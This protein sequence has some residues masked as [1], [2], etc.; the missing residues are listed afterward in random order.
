MKIF[1]D[2]IAFNLQKAGGISVYWSELVKRFACSG[3]DMTFIEQDGEIS[4]IF[5][6]QIDISS[7][8]IVY[9]KAM[10]TRISR[11]LSLRLNINSPSVFHSSYFR[12]CKN[13]KA[14]NIVTV[15]DCTYELFSSGLKQKVHLW[16]KKQ[17]LNSADSI[18]CVSENTKSDLLKFYTHLPPH[19]V[20]VIYNGAGDDFFPL[21]RNLHFTGFYENIRDKKY[22]LYVGGRNSYK[23]FNI[24]IEAVSLLNDFSLVAVGGGELTDNENI[25]LSSIRDRF[26]HVKSP[27]SKDLNLLYNFAFCLLYPSSYEGFGIPIAEAMKAGCPVVTSSVSSIPEVAGDAGLMVETIC[28]AEI[29]AKINALNQESF[30]A[31]VI[32][33]GFVQGNKFSW[34]RCF[35]ETIECY[36]QAYENKL[37]S[38]NSYVK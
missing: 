35:R 5:R 19:K 9:Q 14:V 11:Y 21:E 2:N 24:A 31:E 28:T 18:I 13:P 3:H 34:D 16:Q 30:R 20:K 1:L 6:T 26:F 7:S 17:A 4:N 8:N 25:K 36:E 12:I 38:R 29:I 23:N 10:L 15:H 32:E 27:S 33:R 37:L 22:I